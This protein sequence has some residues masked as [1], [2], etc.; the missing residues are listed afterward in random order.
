MRHRRL[1][2]GLLALAVVLGG[3]PA[4]QLVRQEFVPSDVDE[5]EFEMQITAPEGTSTA[6]MDEIL[7]LDAGRVV[8]RGTHAELLGAGGCYARLWHHER[9]ESA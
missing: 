8:E 1:A 2:L 9:R 6:A 7:V 5:A 3:Y 4:Y